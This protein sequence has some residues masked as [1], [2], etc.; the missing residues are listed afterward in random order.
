M[1]KEKLIL[2]IMREAEED[3]EPVSREEAEEMAEMELKAKGIKNYV[4]SEPTKK[5]TAPKPRKVDTEK[6]AILDMLAEGLTSNNITPTYE[7][8]VKLHFTHNG[9][10]YSITL[11]KHRPPKK[12][13]WS[14]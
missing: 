4:Q 2:Q 14:F 5:K 12:Q 1:D 13:G 3:G 9:S 10:E 6:L 8:E 7:N 11:T